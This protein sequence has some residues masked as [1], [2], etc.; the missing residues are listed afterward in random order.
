MGSLAGMDLRGLSPQDVAT[1]LSGAVNTR[2]LEQSQAQHEDMM[3]YRGQT[4]ALAQMNAMLDA[5]REQRLQKKAQ[6]DEEAVTY[7]SPIT[8]DG[9]LYQRK[10]IGGTDAGLEEIG[11]APEKGPYDKFVRPDGKIEYLKEGAEVPDGWEPLSTRDPLLQ[12]LTQSN[13]NTQRAKQ[14]ET[15]AKYKLG[16]EDDNR[17][18]EERKIFADLFNAIS[19]DFQYEMVEVPK[20]LS[21]LWRGGTD[22]KLVPKQNRGAQQTPPAQQQQAQPAQAQQHPMPQTQEEFDAL[23]A[24]T[25]YVDPDDGKL[26]RK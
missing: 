21:N 6:S 20:K 2:Q 18:P 8:M 10:S 25:I 23:P 11:E 3:G 26:Y 24:G 19:P 5:I 9:K 12:S 17:T 4:N 14:E 22:F 15:L 1:L 16:V 7:S 13:I